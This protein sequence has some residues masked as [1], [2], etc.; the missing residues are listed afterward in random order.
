[1]PVESSKVVLCITAWDFNNVSSIQIAN[2]SIENKHFYP[3]HGFC[4]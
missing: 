3:V 4:A 1:M 2:A